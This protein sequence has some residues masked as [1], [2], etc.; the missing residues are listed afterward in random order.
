MS[1][2]VDEFCDKLRDR[3]NA[4]EVK[5]QSVKEDIRAM[6]GQAE[7]IVRGKLD[8]ARARLQ[9]QKAHIDQ[10]RSNLQ[11]WAQQKMAETKETVAQ[12]QAKREVNKLN[13]R[14]DR[15]ADYAVAAVAFAAAMIDEAE[16]AVL[17]AVVAR[18]EADA[19]KQPEGQQ[20]AL[21]GR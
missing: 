4:I 1:A 2:K 19:A 14:A 18:R 5:L 8:E 21:S 17:D 7:K 20:P 6:P 15:A 13:A 11:A 12:W 3:L 10:T 9:A 16:T